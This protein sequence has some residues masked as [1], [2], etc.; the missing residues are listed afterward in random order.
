[1]AILAAIAIPN[2]IEAQV[3][4]KVSRSQTDMRSIGVAIEAYRVDHTGY[5]PYYAGPEGAG[6]AYTRL[7]VLSTPVAFMTQ[8]PTDPFAD[9]AADR[10]AWRWREDAYIYAPLANW[11]V[12]RTYQDARE[13]GGMW[14]LAGRGPNRIHD[15]Y[16]NYSEV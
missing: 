1:I 4:A 10:V 15:M 9:E 12:G 8:I 3:R 5:P 11:G 13:H 2:F 6:L 16:Y 14:F 7:N